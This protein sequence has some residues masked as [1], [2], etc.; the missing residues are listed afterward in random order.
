VGV[1]GGGG[2]FFLVWCFVGGGAPFLVGGLGFGVGLVLGVGGVFGVWGWVFFCFFVGGV[3][4]G[5]CWF[6]VGLVV[7]L[8]WL[9]GLGVFFWGVGFFVGGGVWGLISDG[10]FAQVSR[11]PLLPPALSTGL[12]TRDSLRRLMTPS[13]KGP[14]PIQ[15][16]A[17]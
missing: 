12:V 8:G 17:R 6:F 10:P 2:C 15:V 16:S 4:V 7:G 3:V 1:C 11:F 13:C 9:G 14:P 5:C